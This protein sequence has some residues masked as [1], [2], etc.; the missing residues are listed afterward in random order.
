[1]NNRECVSGWATVAAMC[2]AGGATFGQAIVMGPSN[3]GFPGSV[4][5]TG[6]NSVIQHTST[7]DTNGYFP[8]N[9]YT[10]DLIANSPV[11]RLAGTTFAGGSFVH[12]NHSDF[13]TYTT[14]A[15]TSTI[16]AAIRNANSLFGSPG[17]TVMGYCGSSQFFMF[18]LPSP[19]NVTMAWG[20]SL[21]AGLPP[22]SVVMFWDIY[23]Q[24]PTPGSVA[25]SSNVDNGVWSGTLPAGQYSMIYTRH[26]GL[27]GQNMDYSNMI[28]QFTLTAEIVPAP[29]GA[30]VLS[31][32]TAAG[33]RR[34][35]RVQ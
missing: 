29:G 13:G 15:T 16:N 35:R 33:L 30:L 12:S 2:V 32:L 10:D 6:S 7:Y 14:T 21:L 25:G 31:G 20:T 5:P 19:A 3:T 18:T 8:P 1:M 28:S 9:V 27:T 22:T 34:R 17:D 23:Q 11:S 26:D 4:A 24:S